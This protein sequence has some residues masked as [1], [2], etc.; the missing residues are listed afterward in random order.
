MPSTN[1]VEAAREL[2][3][4]QRFDD[5]LKLWQELLATD[6]SLHVPRLGAAS[7]CM[8]LGKLD[9]ARILYS[10]AITHRPN[11][12]AAY[13]GLAKLSEL[14]DNFLES[15]SYWKKAW[16]IQPD[17]TELIVYHIENLILAEHPDYKNVISDHLVDIGQMERGNIR[18]ANA[19]SRIQDTKTECK[20]LIEA[21][22]SNKNTQNA[23][24]LVRR[25]LRLLW[26]QQSDNCSSQV[27]DSCWHNHRQG[28]IDH[29]YNT[30][31][32][33]PLLPIEAKWLCDNERT[34]LESTPDKLFQNKQLI[35]RAYL[36]GKD[37]QLAITK[38][39]EQKERLIQAADIEDIEYLAMLAECS[40][41]SGDNEA[42]ARTL[43][44]LA[45]RVI[46]EQTAESI[47][48]LLPFGHLVS[49]S[50]DEVIKRVAQRLFDNHVKEHK[51]DTQFA[52][53]LA[54]LCIQSGFYALAEQLHSQLN[55]GPNHWLSV[56][57]VRNTTDRRL[58]ERASSWNLENRGKLTL[59]ALN[60]HPVSCHDKALPSGA[61]PLFAKFKNEEV[62][63]PE[64][65]EYYRNLGVSHFF[66]I[67][68]MSS[69]GALEYLIRQEDVYVWQA[70]GSLEANHH[71]TPWINALI[72]KFSPSHWCVSADVDEYLT[73]SGSESGNSLRN[74]I[75][76]M[77]QHGEEILPAYMLDMFPD[78]VSGIRMLEGREKLQ[79]THPWFDNTYRFL[80]SVTPPYQQA[81]G[82]FRSR[83]W[84]GLC[85]DTLVKTPLFNTANGV[86]LVHANHDTNGG[87]PSAQ[88]AV[89]RHY[90]FSDDIKRRK[91]FS[92]YI[93]KTH[94][95]SSV[96]ETD[97][98]SGYLP[99][100][101]SLKFE[102]SK[103]LE[104]LGLIQTRCG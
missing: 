88:T 14:T 3:Q 1:L 93:S 95:S 26:T 70:S 10:E 100:P 30:T 6:S 16:E 25:L 48:Y 101:D 45:A 2:Q 40:F 65:L 41:E 28:L 81:V 46:S 71:C 64:F 78:N 53:A 47:N 54:R 27:M 92:D 79:D 15:A 52:F 82:G 37:R 23:L 90:R 99:G 36:W 33:G 68:N 35:A 80:G 61:I 86:R 103:Q 83:L 20:F 76:D 94:S 74:L 13:I 102:S 87:I 69:D 56:W 60:S 58:N 12:I 5:S 73:F 57:I 4:A 39:V 66:M 9:E 32:A 38:F 84:P 62:R 8:N 91:E 96:L 50:G 24:D 42:A 43:D 77:E 29:L 17:R 51:V 67:D 97:F 18:V 75:Y 7:D 98:V 89:L 21:C 104:Q 34:I 44:Q 55:P 22:T 85:N 19:L 49:I 11:H 63:L 72:D 59:R 31:F